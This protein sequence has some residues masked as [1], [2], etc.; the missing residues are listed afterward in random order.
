[1]P[2]Y[3]KCPKCDHPYFEV[4]TNKPKNSN[5]ELLFVRC[6]SCGCI[7]GTMDYYNIGARLNELEKKID[8]LS[9]NNDVCLNTVNQ[10]LNIVNQNI[11][12]LH[13]RLK[14]IFISIEK[15]ELFR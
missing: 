10:N 14:R 3:S 1:M 15:E 4:T 5:Y 2:Y 13:A 6:S 8:K 11:A 9:T 7:V 12:N